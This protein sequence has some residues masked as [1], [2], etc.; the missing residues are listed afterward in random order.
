MGNKITKQKLGSIIWESANKLR[1]NLDASEYKDYVLGLILYKFLCERQTEYLLRD[2]LK[3]SDLKYLDT[4]LNFES[5]KIEQDCEIQSKHDVNELKNECIENLGYY[6]DYSNLFNYWLDNKSEFNIQSFQQAFNE[7]NNNINEKYKTLFKD[8]FIKFETGLNNLGSDTKERTKVILD[9]LDTIKKI[10]TTN[11]DYDVLGFIY[12]YLIA[13]FASTA[14]K[15]AGEFYTPHEVSELMSKIIT[16]HL[17]D[18][19]T[20]KVYDPTSGSG[21]LLLNIGEEF[22]KYNN[23]TSPVS[24]YAQE[25]KPDT[26]NLTRMNLIMKGINPTEIHARCGDTL[27][28]DWPMFENNDINSYQHL[29]VDAVV[30]NPP[31]SQKWN[32]EDHEFDSRYSEYGIAPK[33]KADYAFLLHDLYHVASNGIMAIV[34]PHGV[35]FRGN[36]EGVIRKRLIERSNID[37]IIGLPSNMF[38]GTGIP[39]IIM[40]LKK[41]RKGNDILF[42]DASQLYIK[43]DKKNKFTKSHIKKI[44]DIVNNRLEV[45]NLSKK[46][47][48]KE[49]EQNDYNLN[50]SRYIDNFKKQE[51]YDL[52]S[53]MYGG[54]SNQELDKYQ[55][56][57]D[58]FK[59]LKDKLIKLN[60]NSYYEFLKDIDI[61]KIIYDD[62]QVKTYLDNVKDKSEKFKNYFKTLITSINDIKDVNLMKLEQQLSEYVFNNFN[63]ISFV[64]VYDIYQIIINNLEPIKED[65]WLISKY[66]LNNFQYK[67]NICYE[68]LL[69]EIDTLEK[70]K[71]SKLVKKW[72]SNILDKTLIE[73]TYFKETFDQISEFEQQL[74]FLNSQLEEI[75]SSINE[76]DKTDEIYDSEK[77]EW[78]EKEIK[79]L[80]KSLIKSKEVFDQD[81]FEYNII[82]A[83]D[84]YVEQDKFKKSKNKLFKQLINDSYN[85]YLSLNETEFYDLLIKKWLDK[86]VGQL[87]QVSTDAIDNYVSQFESLENKYKDTLSDINDQILD[88]ERQLSTLLKDLKGEESDLKAIQELISILGSE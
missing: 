30:S 22:K 50:I 58:V 49:I 79:D 72:S 8:I 84:V 13:R 15:N 41:Y 44:S 3:K 27:E 20:I 10:P 66:Y 67:D 26:F 4:K 68:I 33:S 86:I 65:I 43:D 19:E 54:I 42:V 75:F 87:K 2:W 47:S 7:F 80:A 18:R 83:N 25:I 76:E 14:G 23:K 37:T 32:P 48:L 88:N 71:K 38:Y 82:K 60:K 59:N 78:K 5:I 81:S 46:V 12:E 36:Q 11:Q 69:N 57:F 1:K 73:E 77:E 17:K 24:Y 61:R 21:S 55:D 70:E 63:D 6:I 16:F 35:L 39:T 29:S 40:I 64:D 74:E 28:Q 45:K 51:Q 52:Y 85:K 34:L 62:I 9:L 53:L 31:Y 56:F